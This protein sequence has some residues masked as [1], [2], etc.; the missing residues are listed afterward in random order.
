MSYCTAIPTMKDAD[1]ELHK[2]YHDTLY[3]FP[4]ESDDELFCRL[5]LEINQ[6]GLSWTTILKKEESFRKAYSNFNIKKVAAYKQ[7]NIEC[8]LNDANIIRNKLKVNAA[9]ENAKTI[10]AL[11]KQHGSFKNW[12][13]HHHPL[14][15]AEWTKLFKTTFKFTGG[16]IVNEF[17]MSA[18]YLPG[19]HDESCPIYN[20]I[21]KHNP[22]WKQKL[23]K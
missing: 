16:E 4:I 21:I 6:A 7:K 10:A 5:V 20:K 17:L 11:Q 23:K 18:G 15:K 8:L 2:K 22:A 12:L 13:N 3:G 1:K 19:A 14:S 9:I